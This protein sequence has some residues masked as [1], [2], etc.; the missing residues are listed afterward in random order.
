M[1]SYSYLEVREE[2]D[3]LQYKR[4]ILFKEVRFILKIAYLMD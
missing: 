4:K 3:K 2:A 1:F